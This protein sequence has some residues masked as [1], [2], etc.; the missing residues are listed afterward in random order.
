MMPAIAKTSAHRQSYA[1]HTSRKVNKR[2]PTEEENW[3]L[4]Q[5][6]LENDT[7]HLMSDDRLTVFAS[8]S[9]AFVTYW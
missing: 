8:R 2:K 1:K 3:L 7:Q 5:I 4:T 9:A 6:Q